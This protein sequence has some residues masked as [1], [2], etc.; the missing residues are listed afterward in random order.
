M[1]STYSAAAKTAAPALKRIGFT[2]ATLSLSV[3]LAYAAPVFEQLD[4]NYGGRVMV[5]SG[6]SLPGNDIT[7][8]GSGF[9]PGQEITL[10]NN[11]TVL[12]PKGAYVADDKGEFE[13]NLSLPKTAQPGTHPVVVQTS[14]PSFAAVA[15][16]KISPDVPLS[17]QEAFDVT[18]NKLVQ[19][20]YQSAYSAKNDVIFVSSAVG[21]PP[22]K[23][24]TILKV[25]AKTL[26][27][28]ADVTPAADASNNDGRL[29]AVYGVAVDDANDTVWFTNTRQNTMAVYKQSDLSLVKQFDIGAAPHSRDVFIDEKRGKAYVATPFEAQLVIIDTKTLEPVKNLPLNSSKR[30]STFGSF[31]MVLDHDTDKLYVVSGQ[32]AEVAVIDAKTDTVEKVFPVQG[33]RFTT[34]IALDPKTKRLFISAQGSD[35]LL[36]VDPASGETLHDVAVGAGALSVAFD[37]VSEKAYVANRGAGTVTVVDTEGKIVANLDGGTFPNHVSVDGKGNIYVVNKSR[38]KDDPKGDRISIIKPKK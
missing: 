9:K 25:N 14:N 18:A 36:I 38:G 19:G 37:P 35:N 27:I 2:L 4:T 20:L 7:V 30:G 5:T 34:G 26:D 3:S 15:D 10:I 12:N 32:S 16:L 6:Q 17:G 22:V 23:E 29:M 28:E 13:A 31:S 33:A 11:G 21:R 1:I 8:K 24:S